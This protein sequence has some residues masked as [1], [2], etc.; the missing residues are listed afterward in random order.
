MRN[1]IRSLMTFDPITVHIDMNDFTILLI[2]VRKYIY[3]YININFEN[4]NMQVNTFLNND[5]THYKRYR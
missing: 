5:M 3:M 1:V 2:H 4:V